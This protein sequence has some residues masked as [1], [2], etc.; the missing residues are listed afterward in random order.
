MNEILI[1]TKALPNVIREGNT[2]MLTSFMQSG[3]KLGMQTMD[4]ALFA[5][6]KLGEIL[7]RDAYLKATEKGRFEPLLP[8]E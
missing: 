3:K 5:L 1:K 2:S 7:P 4:D 6:A 8:P